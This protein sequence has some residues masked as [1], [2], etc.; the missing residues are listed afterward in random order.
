MKKVMVRAWE[1]ARAAAAKFG[2]S[3]VEYMSGALRQ[4]WAE[5]KKVTIVTSSGSR[6]HKSWVAKIDGT[7]ARY[8]FK[9]TFIDAVDQNWTEKRFELGAG[10]Y[11]VCD[12]G[13]R[14]FIRVSGGKIK[15]IGKGE[16]M[17]AVA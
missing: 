6:K 5:T 2:G 4:A 16:V 17:E 3:A 11:E 14:K 7:D 13:E 1:I 10:V 9:R 8:G 12:A 15:V